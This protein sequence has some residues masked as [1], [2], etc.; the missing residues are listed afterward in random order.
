MPCR[1]PK[2]GKVVLEPHARRAAFYDPLHCLQPLS[3][4]VRREWHLRLNRFAT[5]LLAE[6]RE[7]GQT[8]P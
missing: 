8:R 6:W 4:V 7:L 3:C 5:A 1:E 2:Q